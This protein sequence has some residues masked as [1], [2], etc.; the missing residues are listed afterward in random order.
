MTKAI[1]FA[2]IGMFG[3][4]HS[5][6]KCGE[7]MNWIFDNLYACREL[8]ALLFSPV[9]AK[10][11]ISLTEMMILLFLDCAEIENTASALTERLKIAKSHISS[12]I[13]DLE[14]RGL[15]KGNFEGEN[16]RTIHLQL[17]EKAQEIVSEGRTVQKNL[18]HVIS[19]GFSTEEA[20]QVRSLLMRITENANSYIKKATDVG[21]TTFSK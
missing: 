1:F 14:D 21:K 5:Y 11:K 13:H 2:I 20:E 7:K 12:S 6:L 9:C 3:N 15:L 18:I 8:Q 4:E 10:Y 19:Q 16:H 17:C